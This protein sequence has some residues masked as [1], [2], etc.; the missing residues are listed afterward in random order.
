MNI[1]DRN[2]WYALK[3]K[4]KTIAAFIKHGYGQIRKKEEEEGYSCIS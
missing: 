2:L 3:K 1:V 4:K